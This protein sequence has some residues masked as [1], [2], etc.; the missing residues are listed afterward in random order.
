MSTNVPWPQWIITAHRP[1]LR[2]INIVHDELP[3]HQARITVALCGQSSSFVETFSRRE[4]VCQRCVKAWKRKFPGL[5]LHSDLPLS[6][7]LIQQEIREEL[8]QR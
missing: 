3:P 6:V 2:H 8:K 4:L 5:P 7:V 1:T